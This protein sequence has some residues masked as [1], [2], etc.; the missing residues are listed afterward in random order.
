MRGLGLFDRG[1]WLRE[2]KRWIDAPPPG[3]LDGRDPDPIRGGPSRLVIARDEGALDAAGA[4][5]GEA[6]R[7]ML[8]RGLCAL[9]D[10][11]DERTAWASLLHE[12]RP[13]DVVGIKLNTVAVHLAPHRAV[14][15]AVVE[16]LAE[17]GVEPHH[18]VLWDNLGRLGPLRMRFY[19]DLDRPEGA[20]Y[21]GMARAGFAPDRYKA[22]RLLCTVPRPPGLGYDRRVRAEVPSQGLRLPVSRIL[23]RVCDHVINLPV[24]KDHRVTGVTCALKNFYGCVPLWDAFRPTH[25]DRMHASR[26]DPQIAELYANPCIS[27][28]VRLHLCDALRAICDGGPW[29]EPQLEPRS[30][31]L[32]TDPVALDAYVLAM[33]DGARRVLGMERVARRARYIESAARRGLGTNDPSSIDALD[34]EGKPRPWPR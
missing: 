13:D 20:Y 26:G 9:T 30:L 19:G 32:A 25:A 1:L 10:E 28:K 3:P 12:L 34:Q 15:D 14:V 16:S 6:I 17:V 18:V 29:G 5:R 8:A 21:Q 22:P 31:L 27:G 24:P 33:I 11:P 4:P 7:A 2:R 23:T